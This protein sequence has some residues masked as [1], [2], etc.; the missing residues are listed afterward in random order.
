MMGSFVSFSQTTTT[1]VEKNP[2]TGETTEKTTV[3][4][5]TVVTT[6]KKSKL[7]VQPIERPKKLRKT[8]VIEKKKEED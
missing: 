7:N 3:G 8:E 6:K 1:T 2:I 4:N 5:T